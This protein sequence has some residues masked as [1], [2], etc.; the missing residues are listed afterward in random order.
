MLQFFMHKAQ[1]YRHVAT[2]QRHNQ[3]VALKIEL[4]LINFNFSLFGNYGKE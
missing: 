3:M 4:N 1:S 2:L